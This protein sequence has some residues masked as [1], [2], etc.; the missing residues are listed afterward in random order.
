MYKV[1][2]KKQAKKKLLSINTKDKIRLTEK[3]VRL[4]YDPED[5]SLKIKK[6]TGQ[7]GYRLKVGDWRVIFLRDDDIMVIAVEKIKPRGDVYK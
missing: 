7:P 3:I 5:P 6:L 4:G 1:I 2:I